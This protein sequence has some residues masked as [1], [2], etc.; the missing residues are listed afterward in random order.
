MRAEFVL[1]IDDLNQFDWASIIK[2]PSERVCEQY[3]HAFSAAATEAKAKSDEKMQ[4]LSLLFSDMTSMMLQPSEKFEIF[5][6]LVTWADG[7]R[8]AI[9]ADFYDQHLEVL[10]EWLPSCTDAEL[11]AR[12]ADII[13]TR[14][15]QGNFSVAEL[16]IKSYLESGKQLLESEFPHYGISKLTRSVHLAANLGRGTQW[17]PKIVGEFEVLIEKYSKKNAS[18]IVDLME[19]LLEYKQGNPIK[20]AKFAEELA[21][22]QEEN[23]DWYPARRTWEIEIKW[24]RI[25][26]DQPEEIV[27]LEKIASTYILEA[28]ENIKNGRGHMVAA[29]NIQSAI[30]TLRQIPGTKD[31]QNKLHK[32]ML[33][34]QK[35]S[36]EELGHFQ[37][38][39]ID[40]TPDIEAF[41]SQIKG[42]NFLDA[43]FTLAMGSAL[44]SK[45]GMVKLV[46]EMATNSPSSF[47]PEQ[48]YRCNR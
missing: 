41:F 7:S 26:K 25:A 19:L 1:A 20:Y 33:E 2:D 16:A 43:I 39:T 40:L 13:W 29:H 10:K 15:H 23:K 8:S 6:P 37:S 42:K 28:E 30:E 35:Q 46:E 21:L 32:T 17:F 9:V 31:R 5:A 38:E 24:H 34:Y 44:V 4:Q 36:L 18:F 45:K 27:I 3:C 12:I 14:K 47:N 22:N 11:R 48:G